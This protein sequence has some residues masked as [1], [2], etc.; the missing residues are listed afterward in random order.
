MNADIFESLQGLLPL[1]FIIIWVVARLGKKAKDEAEEH[2]D[3]LAT[4]P[5]KKE[6]QTAIER[7]EKKEKPLL[8]SLRRSLEEFMEDISGESPPETV[9][10]PKA[11]AKRKQDS[12]R[13]KKLQSKRTTEKRQRIETMEPRLQSDRKGS[14]GE[15][16]FAMPALSVETP[17]SEPLSAV[18]LDLSPSSLRDA[19]VLSEIISAPV[20]LR[21]GQNP[22]LFHCG[23]QPL[24]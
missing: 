9:P 22:L 19:I 20:A 3:N 6:N 23:Q 8:G 5:R 1:I 10:V 21:R 12:D 24:P 15:S 17:D 13:K 18:E 4:A 16:S 11:D 2:A 14:Y 7:E